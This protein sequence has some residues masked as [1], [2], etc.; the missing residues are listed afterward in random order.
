MVNADLV[1]AKLVE[2]SERVGRARA[3]RPST[4]SA[5]AADRD[6]QDLVAF[7]LM[8]AVQICTDVATH[9]IADEGWTAATTMSSSFARLAEHGVIDQE[10]ARRLGKAVG[11]RNVVAHGYAG[12]DPVRL[13]EAASTGVDDLDAYARAVASWVRTRAPAP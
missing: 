5:L 7:N 4:A 6:A 12:V 13:F 1:A 9:L 10:L 2:L 11:L 8:L 3:R